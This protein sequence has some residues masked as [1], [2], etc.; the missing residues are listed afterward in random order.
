[1]CKN[2]LHWVFVLFTVDYFRREECLTFG[3]LKMR[4]C[5]DLGMWRFE[6]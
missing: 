3:D 2:I 5:G 6:D 1:M 4:K